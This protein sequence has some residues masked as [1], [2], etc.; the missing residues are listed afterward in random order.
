MPPVPQFPPQHPAVPFCQTT[1]TG[2]VPPPGRAVGCALGPMGAELVLQPLSSHTRQLR[3]P[4][5]T[6]PAM[7]IPNLAFPS[8]AIGPPF[9]LLSPGIPGGHGRLLK[10]MGQLNRFR[11]RIKLE[12]GLA[13]DRA[14]SPQPQI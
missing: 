13:G 5:P 9:F 1:W 6:I 10:G 8:E 7:P 2:V 12:F 4:A 14:R 3:K 11:L